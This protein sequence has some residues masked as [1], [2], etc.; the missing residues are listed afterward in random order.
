MRGRAE[1]ES[2]R[3]T[4]F[5]CGGQ[6]SGGRPT[7]T[8]RQTRGGTDYPQADDVKT[9]WLDVMLWAVMA[10][11]PEIARCLW[12]KVAEPMRAAI[13]AAHVAFGVARNYLPL[14][15]DPQRTDSTTTPPE[16]HRDRRSGQLRGPDWPISLH[17]SDLRLG[18]PR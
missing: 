11:E 9:S 8:L 1:A 6:G 4:R 12:A 18:E 17:R 10:G 2:A 13:W 14:P 3:V 7:P 15:R 5:A 16:L